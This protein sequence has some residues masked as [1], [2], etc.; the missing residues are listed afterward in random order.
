ML[1]VFSKA[2]RS[3]CTQVYIVCEVKFYYNLSLDDPLDEVV[4]VK[5]GQF[6]IRGKEA[7]NNRIYCTFV[8]RTHNILKEITLT[9]SLLKKVPLGP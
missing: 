4:T 2:P 1:L 6:S 7:L 8:I 9:P 5:I 3:K